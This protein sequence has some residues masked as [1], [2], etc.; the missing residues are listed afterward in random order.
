MRPFSDSDIKSLREMLRSRA[1]MKF[2]CSMYPMNTR[3]E[4]VE[5]IDACRRFADDAEARAWVNQVLTYQWGDVP[6]ING[7]VAE[8]V[9]RPWT[10]EHPA[11][12][13]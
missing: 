5:A 10:D 13:P 12:Q 7:R 4:M 1:D 3:N 9:M 6:L 11:P 2:I 8:S